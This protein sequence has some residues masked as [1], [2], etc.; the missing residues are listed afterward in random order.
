MY[1]THGTCY[2]SHWHSAGHTAYLF[3]LTIR[4]SCFKMMYQL[5][6]PTGAYTSHLLPAL[7]SIAPS[8]WGP[9]K[10]TFRMKGSQNCS[11]LSCHIRNVYLTFVVCRLVIEKD[12]TPHSL[13]T[14]RNLLPRWIQLIYVILYRNM[15]QIRT[16]TNLP[17]LNCETSPHSCSGP[18]R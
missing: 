16:T 5:S 3:S 15:L 17:D 13:P 12:S 2:Y 6:D 4:R 9:P 18:H 14:V 1:S 7:K 8:A 11:A 10:H